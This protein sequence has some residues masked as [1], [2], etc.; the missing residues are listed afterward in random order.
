MKH[1]DLQYLLGCIV[2]LESYQSDKLQALV[3]LLQIETKVENVRFETCREKEE[4]EEEEVK[5]D[6]ESCC[7]DDDQISK[8]GELELAKTDIKEEDYYEVSVE[9]AGQKMF[10]CKRCQYST[11]QKFMIQMHIRQELLSSL[12]SVFLLITINPQEVHW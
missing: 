11:V 4:S 12:P 7:S 10:R 8:S 9:D 6:V 2:G 1:R 3:Q 5:Q